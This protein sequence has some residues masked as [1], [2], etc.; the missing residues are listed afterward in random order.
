MRRQARV[1]IYAP[2]A[3][4]SLGSLSGKRAPAS[5]ARQWVWFVQVFNGG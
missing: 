1:V 2:D 3:A 5:E 4:R